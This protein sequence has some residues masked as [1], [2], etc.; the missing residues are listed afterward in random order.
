[1]R[2]PVLCS[3]V[4]VVPWQPTRL[5]AG[6]HVIQ[7]F[8]GAGGLRDVY[9]TTGLLPTAANLPQTEAYT[10]VMVWH[11]DHVQ[12]LTLRGLFETDDLD[13][14]PS[15]SILRETIAWKED[16]HHPC[17]RACTDPHQPV[18]VPRRCVLRR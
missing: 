14:I 12:F 4:R 10:A 15:G 1:M 9:H 17:T 3:G 2:V 13:S 11:E 16:T 5:D 7:P 8:N 18:A 6:Q